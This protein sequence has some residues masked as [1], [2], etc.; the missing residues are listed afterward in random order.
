M[1][2]SEKIRNVCMRKFRPNLYL[3]NI[4]LYN[5]LEKTITIEIK[6]GGKEVKTIYIIEDLPF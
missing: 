4:D 1:K 5:R 3:Y 6:Q 2:Y